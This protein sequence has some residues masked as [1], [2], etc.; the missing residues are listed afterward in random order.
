MKLFQFSEVVP[1]VLKFE[2]SFFNYPNMIEAVGIY[3]NVSS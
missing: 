1:I 2:L 3:P